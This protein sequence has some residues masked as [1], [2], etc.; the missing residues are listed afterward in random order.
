MLNI[1]SLIKF[2]V[3]LNTNVNINASDDEIDK[4]IFTS[5]GFTKDE[6]LYINSQI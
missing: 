2:P 4:D 3:P 6:I 1:Q 5:Y